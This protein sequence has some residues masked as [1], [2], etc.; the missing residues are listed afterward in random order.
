MKEEL[1][2]KKAFLLLVTG[3]IYNF[4][5]L[6]ASSYLLHLQS[7]VSWT[8]IPLCNATVVETAR[9][10][11]T[12][13]IHTS[14]VKCA[15]KARRCIKLSFIRGTA[16]IWEQIQSNKL[17]LILKM[18][19]W[20]FIFFNSPRFSQR[21]VFLES[22]VNSEEMLSVTFCIKV[23]WQ[24]WKMEVF[25]EAYQSFVSGL[26]SSSSFVHIAVRAAPTGCLGSLQGRG[27]AALPSQRCFSALVLLQ[28]PLCLVKE[29]IYLSVIG[30]F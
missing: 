9:W 1:G 25:L 17:Y 4:L 22:V 14:G 21:T 12:I 24:M 11:I 6:R 20:D 30:Q 26:N 15:M 27:T 18:H 13:V 23:T 8:V 29:C 2:Q 16:R 5:C 28:P 19:P 3:F 7:I 10:G